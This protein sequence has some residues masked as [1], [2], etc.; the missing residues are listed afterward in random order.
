MA[1]RT[2]TTQQQPWRPQ[3]EALTGYF[4]H[5]TNAAG[6]G[7][8]YDPQPLS[9]D[10]Q[11]SIRASRD[12]MRNPNPVRE[13]GGDYLSGFLSG[14]MDYNQ[15][16]LDDT[17]QNA[18]MAN[19]YNLGGFANDPRMADTY[20][21]TDTA[22][23]P[24]RAFGYGLEGAARGDFLGSNPYFD[25]ALEASLDPVESRVNSQ[26][27]AS[28][29]YGS[30]MHS[31]QMTEKLGDVASQM[32]MQQYESE[33]QRQQ[34]AASRLAGLENQALGRQLSAQQSLG[35]LSNRAINR[36]FN[37]NTEMANLSD[38]ALQ[39]ELTAQQ[40]LINADA[41]MRDDLRQA[42]GMADNYQAMRMNDISQL[43]SAGNLQDQ[44]KREYADRDY[45]TLTRL[46]GLLSGNYGG[47]S[48]T[49]QYYDPVG[50]TIGNIASGAG[51]A[52]DL[53]GVADTISDF[54]F[55]W[56]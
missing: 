25:A 34:Q 12:Q 4:D 36:Q 29:R 43:R 48:S 6:Q 7:R 1:K 47:T 18:E 45:Q 28:G 46:Q 30:G 22:E 33:R 27:A 52:A 24:E 21:M 20:G 51:A 9:Q 10:T 11:W 42:A 40:A 50:Q 32:G 19:T 55:L 54:D 26:F 35:D 39:R 17:A 38:R 41:R 13:A 8:V 44:K 15:Y 3:R 49:P 53:A 56:G 16:G 23:S 14:G 2:V 37:A 5:V 31:G